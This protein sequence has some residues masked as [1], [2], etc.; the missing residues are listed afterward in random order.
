MKKKKLSSREEYEKCNAQAMIC[1]NELA[2]RIDKFNAAFFR[3]LGSRRKVQFYAETINSM[4]QVFGSEFLFAVC[5]FLRIELERIQTIKE[6]E[7]SRRD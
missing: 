4:L 6:E 7:T 2:D 5:L 3:G 1:V